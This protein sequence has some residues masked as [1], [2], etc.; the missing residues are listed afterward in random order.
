MMKKLYIIFTVLFLATELFAS[1]QKE[2][3]AITTLSDIDGRSVA[4]IGANFDVGPDFFEGH[5]YRPKSVLAFDSGPE[6][7]TALKAGKADAWVGLMMSLANYYTRNDSSLLAIPDPAF[8]SYDLSLTVA[9]SN[10]SLLNTL[11]KAIADIKADGT[12]EQI[13]ETYFIRGNTERTA[14]PASIDGQ[15]TVIV[16]LPGDGPPI[17][18]I[19]PDGKP[20]GYNLALSNAIAKAAGFN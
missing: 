2:S 20:S 15:E 9:E 4:I 12:L 13:T 1:A 19:A 6:A 16:G 3:G 7:L 8:T 11:N 18:Y 10:T 17:D 5:G 14:S